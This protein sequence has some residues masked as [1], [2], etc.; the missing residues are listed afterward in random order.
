MVSA[1]RA[2]LVSW[3][4][5]GKGRSLDVTKKP[6]QPDFAHLQGLGLAISNPK[7]ITPDECGADGQLKLEVYQELPYAPDGEG[8][9]WVVEAA[10][11]K[12][13]GLADLEVRYVYYAVPR[14]G[15]EVQVFSAVVSID[16]KTYIRYFWI[17][18]PGSQRLLSVLAAAVVML[19]LE[20]RRATEIPLSFRQDLEEQHHPELV[21]NA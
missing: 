4:D 17:F 15:D 10:D 16:R 7:T 3:P 19:D 6:S 18:D 1:A 8:V 20:A 13:L 5:H 21:L 2:R 14:V 9:N 11:G 12:Q